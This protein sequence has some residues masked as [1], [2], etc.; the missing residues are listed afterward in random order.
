MEP[1]KR[2]QKAVQFLKKQNPDLKY[3]HIMTRLGYSSPNYLAD[4]LNGN[5]EIADKFLK[6]FEQEFF[7]RATWIKTGKGPEMITAKQMGVR[8]NN[9]KGPVTISDLNKAVITLAREIAEIK[10]KG[11]GLDPDLYFYE[12]LAKII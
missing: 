5:K 10:A 9:S 11:T 6:V 1:Y 8:L 2:L 4:M 12:L 7:F 3:K